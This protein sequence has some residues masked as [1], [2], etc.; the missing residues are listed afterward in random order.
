MENLYNDDDLLAHLDGIEP[1]GDLFRSLLPVHMESVE[2]PFEDNVIKLKQGDI[3]EIAYW[4]PRGY[5]RAYIQVPGKFPDEVKEETI[6][7][8]KKGL[9]V[10]KDSFF[11]RQASVHYLEI[12]KNSVIRGIT[13]EN[14]QVMKAR[15]KEANELIGKI[16][17][18][19]YAEI[20]YRA[21]LLR[22]PCKG[23]Y[24]LFL[25]DFDAKIEQYFDLR[26]IAS[27]LGMDPTTLAILRSGGRGK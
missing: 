1:L 21:K 27:Y 8:W 13:Y 25:S 18:E 17:A 9:V 14:L 19:D 2:G 5:G 20:F 15:T 11:K 26:H 10:V 7:F 4:M 12:A 22:M 24:D 3:S 6:N 23:R 16:L